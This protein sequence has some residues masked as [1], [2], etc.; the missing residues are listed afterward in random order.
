MAKFEV[1]KSTSVVVNDDKNGRKLI[2]LVTG[3]SGNKETVTLR[4]YTNDGQEGAKI[5]LYRN[6]LLDAILNLYPENVAYK[7]DDEEDEED[8]IPF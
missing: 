6:T 3:I 7:F 4:T 1:T 2:S 8:E 5:T